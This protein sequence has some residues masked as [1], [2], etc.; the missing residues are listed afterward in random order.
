MNDA[1]ITVRAS[2]TRLPNKCFL[3]LPGETFVLKHVIDRCK[4][5]NLNPVVST[6]YQDV[7]IQTLCSVMGVR[8]YAGSIDDKLVRWLETC[9]KFSIERFVTVDCDDPL[10]DQDL[11]NKLFD[12]DDFDVCRPD[13]N[14]YLGSMGW[15]FKTS[16]IERCCQE[17]QSDKT[18][19]VW[20]YFSKSLRIKQC[21]AFPSFLEKKIRLTLDY[22][23]DYWLI[24]TVIREL[25]NDCD[26]RQIVNFFEKNPSLTLINQFRNDEWK[27]NQNV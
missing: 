27:Q 23:E 9:R 10:F 21:D 1:L 25:G 11:T 13:M 16:A 20:K 8:C 26:R 7:S 17:K 6:T 22:N 15:G 14:A 24:S 19:M 12:L 4:K 18:E 5:F 3:S 2:S